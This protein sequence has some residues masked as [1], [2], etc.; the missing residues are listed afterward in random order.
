MVNRHF[1]RKILL[2]KIKKQKITLCKKIII[3]YLQEILQLTKHNRTKEEED[4]VRLVCSVWYGW[5]A[6]CG[7]TGVQ[8][9][10]RLV[11]SVWY[12]WCAACGTTGVQRVVRLVCSVWYDWCAAC[13]TTGV[14]RVVRPVCSV[15]Y[16]WCAVEQ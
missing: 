9:V 13:G 6:A 14:Q 11:C 16:D 3:V 1:Y 5:C 7:T 8:R 10:V 15:W 12:D 2:L 4:R